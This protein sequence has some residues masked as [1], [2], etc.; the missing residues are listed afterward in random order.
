MRAARAQANL[1][2]ATARDPLGEGEGFGEAFAADVR[3]VWT[4]AIAYNTK[5][6]WLGAIAELMSHIF[7]MRW[8][9]ARPVRLRRPPAD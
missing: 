3:R 6:T 1:E 8:K 4:N 5:L 2:H 7:E 9:Q